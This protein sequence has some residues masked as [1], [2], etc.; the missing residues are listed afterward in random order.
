MGEYWPLAK[1][2]AKPVSEKKNHHGYQKKADQVGGE[3]FGLTSATARQAV[4]GTPRNPRNL[5]DTCSGVVRVSFGCCSG[6]TR[7]TPEGHPKDYRSCPE[8]VPKR[9]R[10]AP[11]G[12]PNSTRRNRWLFDHFFA[13]FKGG[14]KYRCSKEAVP[15]TQP[16]RKIAELLFMYRECTISVRGV[17]RKGTGDLLLIY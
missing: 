2:K 13:V 1:A 3:S 9:T 15:F 16:L 12:H 14:I 5:F 10:S 7:T 17:Y 4:E 6:T 8:P 11:E